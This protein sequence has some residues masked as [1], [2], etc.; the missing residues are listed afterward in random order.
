VV[1]ELRVLR[2]E[3]RRRSRWLPPA[4]FHDAVVFET[5]AVVRGRCQDALTSR[6]SRRPRA[7][8]GVVRNKLLTN[9]YEILARYCAST[10]H[11][12][13]YVLCLICC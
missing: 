2:A 5:G 6:P 10:F 12:A 8:P 3:R 13:A 9:Y 7:V 11:V 1:A 4:P